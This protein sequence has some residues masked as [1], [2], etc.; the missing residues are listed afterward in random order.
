MS[1]LPPGSQLGGYRVA[2]VLGRGGMGVVYLAQQLALERRVALKVISEDLSRDPEFR[3]RFMREAQVAASLDHRRIIPVFDAGEADGRL[4][5]SMRYVKGLDLRTVLQL[6][7]PLEPERALPI[8]ESVGE[9]LDAAHALGLVHRDVKPANVLI[10]D[11]PGPESERVFLTDFG[12]TKRVDAAERSHPDGHLRGHARVLV[13]G[14]VLGEAGGTAGPTCTRWRACC[15]SAWRGRRRSPRDSDAQVLAAHLLEPPPRPSAVRPGLPRTLDDVLAKG[16][17]KEPADRYA[18]C[19]ELVAAAGA[20]LR[21]APAAATVEAPGPFLPAAPT[22]QIPAVPPPVSGDAPTVGGVGM[23]V[24][25]TLV[26][27]GGVAP[28]RRRG[29][30]TVLVLIGILLV[31]GVIVALAIGGGGE[32]KA[33]PSSGPTDGGTS[34]SPT[35]APSGGPSTSSTTTG[36]QGGAALAAYATGVDDLLAESADYRQRLVDAVVGANGAKRKE[37]REDLATVQE[38]ID[39]RQSALEQVGSWDVPPEAGAVNDLLAAAFQD[40]VADDENYALLVQAYIDRDDAT[41]KQILAE[42]ENHR[43]AATTPDKDAFLRSYNALRQRAG[44]EPIP[45]DFQF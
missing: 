6:E 30:V 13:A 31:G 3:E 38:V 19:G 39:Q 41:A 17:A 24:P 45:S 21:A 27:R 33:E 29:L 32:P 22:E 5:L 42:L 34:T 7:R 28:R 44:L 40:A 15:T 35:T 20:A 16:M 23:E 1:D 11:G 37:Q 10:E 9:A 36:G 2:T 25:P 26:G 4:F 43:A 8:L 14:A 12:L 18:T